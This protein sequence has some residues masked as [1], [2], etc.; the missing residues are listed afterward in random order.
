MEPEL[1]EA[2]D[3]ARWRAMVIAAIRQGAPLISAA[4]SYVLWLFRVL[5]VKGC[6]RDEKLRTM[7]SEVTMLSLQRKQ[8]S[9]AG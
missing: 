8:R 3:G 1:V 6:G 4:A 9:Q 5:N 2:V 7:D